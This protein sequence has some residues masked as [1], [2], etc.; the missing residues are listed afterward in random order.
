MQSIKVVSNTNGLPT[1]CFPLGFIVFVS[2]MKDFFE[3]YKRRKSDQAENN[4]F[5]QTFQKEQ[6]VFIKMHWSQLRVGDIIRLEQ[7]EYVPADMLILSSSEPKG[8]L[9]FKYPFRKR[10]K[11]V[12]FIETKNLDGETNL[13]IKT[14]PK[15]IYKG[16]FKFSEG[17]C[18]EKFIFEYERPNPILYTFT[19]FFKKI[20]NFK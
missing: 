20:K 8:E 16:F 10:L 17:I 5:T 18:D 9:N 4:K 1:I 6:Q 3:D 7:N 11:G 19:G 14:A 13:K 15:E 12:C 2:M